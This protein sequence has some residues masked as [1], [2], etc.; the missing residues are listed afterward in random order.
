MNRSVR[1]L[2]L[3]V[4]FVAG[5]TFPSGPTDKGAEGLSSALVSSVRERLS[6]TEQHAIQLTAPEKQH[7]IASLRGRTKADFCAAEMRPEVEAARYHDQR[8]PH[9]EYIG[10]VRHS[11]DGKRRVYLVYRPD[12]GLLLRGG[13]EV[14]PL[15]GVEPWKGW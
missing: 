5:C 9:Q 4:A 12:G 13:G 10:F 14:D 7:L 11:Q 8:E 3:V 1:V 6:D 2:V 15:F